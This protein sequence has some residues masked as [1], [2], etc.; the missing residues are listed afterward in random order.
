MNASSLEL[1]NPAPTAS[2]SLL[3]EAK[4]SWRQ[5]VA[6]YQSPQLRRS[7]WQLANSVVPF[8]ALWYLAY[9]L[10]AVSYW[11]VLPVQILPAAS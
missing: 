3:E 2:A 11:L 7:L 10:L 1:D 5:A 8:L 4:S 6:A 9:R